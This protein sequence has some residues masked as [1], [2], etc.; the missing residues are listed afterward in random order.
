MPLALPFF[1][2]DILEGSVVE[3]KIGHEAFQSSV[4]I[5]ELLEPCSLANI[6]PPILRLPAV[7]GGLANPE[8]AAHIVNFRVS[9]VLNVD[10]V[11]A[12]IPL[13][14]AG[15]V[16]GRS[17]H[18]TAGVALPRHRRRLGVHAETI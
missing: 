14:R 8:G 6:H 13:W 17:S 5:F 11:E 15:S 3:A 4:L 1:C 18:F 2:Q 9:L 12:T 7:I 10:D 16:H